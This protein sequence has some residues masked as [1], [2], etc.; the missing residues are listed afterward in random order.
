[1]YT[2][3]ISPV[4]LLFAQMPLDL[5]EYGI[6]VLLH[7]AVLGKPSD[8]RLGR[9]PVAASIDI[10]MRSLVGEPPQGVAE[11]RY[12]F[13]GLRAAQFDLSVFE[14][15]VS[16]VQCRCRTQIKRACYS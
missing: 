10:E 2:R 12:A 16:R 4:A 3:E 5:F 11:N 1:M 9:V 14:P 6:R 15:A 13:S 7:G 8:T